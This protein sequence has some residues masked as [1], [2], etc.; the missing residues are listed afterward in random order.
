[1]WNNITRYYVE[2]ILLLM[3]ILGLHQL[4]LA[5]NQSVPLDFFS[6]PKLYGFYFI[7]FA[8]VS[9]IIFFVYYLLTEFGGYAY[10]FGILLKMFAVIWFLY[11]LLKSDMPDK[12]IS[13]IL[14]M[15]IFF[16]LLT[17]QVLAVVRLINQGIHRS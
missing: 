16:V 4:L 7:L 3:L 17:H 10:L 12:K 5:F 13:A 2:L 11:P 14:F 1:M 6:L 15:L 9:G 8:G